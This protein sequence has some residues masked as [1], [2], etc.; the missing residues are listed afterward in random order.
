MEPRDR[1][2]H[3]ATD[4]CVYRTSESVIKRGCRFLHAAF[5][6][7][8]SVHLRRARI[9]E[10]TTKCLENRHFGSQ[11]TVWKHV[12]LDKEVKFEEF[13]VVAVDEWCQINSQAL[14]A[15]RYFEYA[16]SQEHRRHLF[17]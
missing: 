9:I 5:Y 15:S 12:R 3:V 1:C 4:N 16:A 17:R 13:S 2:W 10:F 11:S 6:A 14:A 7:C 8:A